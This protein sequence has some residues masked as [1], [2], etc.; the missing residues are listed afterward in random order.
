[1]VQKI[2]LILVVCG[3]V[4]SFDIAKAQQLQ[5]LAQVD[6]ARSEITGRPSGDVDIR[7][8]LSVG[9][10][11][12]AFT[13]DQP[14]RLVLDFQQVDFSGVT[15]DDL[16]KTELIR[17]ARFGIYRP[18]W[19]RLV[20]QL[21]RPMSVHA[22][23]QEIN[24]DTG[25]AVI[26]M[27]LSPQDPV[28]FAANVGAP[29]SDLWA[30]PPD[31]AVSNP[32]RR[33]TGDRKIIVAIDPGHGGIDPGAQYGGNNEADLMLLLA[34]ELKEVLLLSGR[35]DVFLTREEDYFLSLEARVSAARATGADVFMSLHADALARGKASG[36]TVYTLSDV[37]SDD[38]ADFLAASHERSDLLAG[39]DLAAQDDVVASVLM[40]LARLETAPRGEKLAAELV[41]GI[42]KSVG[43]I[44]SRPHLQAA[45]SV[46]KAP[47]IP[48]VLIEF[49]FMSNPL[50]LSN[51]SSAN[52]RKKAINGILAALDVW[53][54][55]DAAEARLL[56]Q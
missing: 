10:P 20:L 50:D 31:V 25:A 52:W 13:L 1:L 42:A 56:R 38:A 14:P 46:L 5:A 34:R 54:I 19:S 29:A 53:A 9:V 21:F 16:L 22:A 4:L 51:L 8:H 43:R 26:K 28:I 49:G 32:K 7:L 41:R 48:S 6:A 33:Q 30:L 44:R 27:R 3:F 23:E 24:N 36:T 18:G 37:A 47:D 12:R 11:Y 17:T 15:P 35:Y 45:F 55:Q 39:V 2:A 40:D